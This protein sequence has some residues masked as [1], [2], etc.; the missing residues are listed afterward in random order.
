MRVYTLGILIHDVG[1]MLFRIKILWPHLQRLCFSR[2][3]IGLGNL[4]FFTVLKNFSSYYRK[5]KLTCV[6]VSVVLFH[7]F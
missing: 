6:C 1:G 7:E 2:L 4:H 3:G 5:V